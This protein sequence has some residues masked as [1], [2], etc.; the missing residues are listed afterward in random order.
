MRGVKQTLIDE[1]FQ[2]IKDNPLLFGQ[3]ADALGVSAFS[4][5]EMIRKKSHRFTEL[6]VLELISRYTDIP[7]K[8]LVRNTKVETV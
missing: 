2:A 1:G 7:V 6:A 8:K 5:P 4:M 3:V